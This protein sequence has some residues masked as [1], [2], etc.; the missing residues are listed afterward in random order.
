MTA[1]RQCRLLWM[2]LIGL[3]SIAVIMALI[4]SVSGVAGLDAVVQTLKPYLF[5]WRVLVFVVVIGGWPVWVDIAVSQQWV[6]LD[7]STELTTYR[8]SLALW[9][10]L[11]E[12]VI[13][14][15]LLVFVVDLIV[16][17]V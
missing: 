5:G 1:K 13:N 4:V 9:L 14:Q 17:L 10:V 12:V 11:L 16:T 7:Q 2:T 6:T 3:V 15:H 8:W